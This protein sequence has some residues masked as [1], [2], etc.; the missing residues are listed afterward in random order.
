MIL[1]VMKN[2]G[3]KMNECKLLKELCLNADIDGFCKVESCEI[4]VL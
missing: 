1:R 2:R 4:E 3:A